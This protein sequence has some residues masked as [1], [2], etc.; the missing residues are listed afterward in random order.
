MPKK[1]LFPHVPGG[2]KGETQ[3]VRPLPET[4][5]SPKRLVYTIDAKLTIELYR[6]GQYVG[7]IV[8]SPRADELRVDI[9]HQGSLDVAERVPSM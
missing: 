9:E 8:V 6:H 2:Q 4:I 7:V 5:R 3:E 1:P